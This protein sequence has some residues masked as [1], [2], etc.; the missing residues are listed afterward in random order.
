MQDPLEQEIL[1]LSSALDNTVQTINMLNKV[2]RNTNCIDLV[3]A[4]KL[5]DAV[6]S[7]KCSQNIF[8]TKINSLQNLKRHQ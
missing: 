5:Q 6:R 4:T 2:M 3:S 1:I 8:E 7:L